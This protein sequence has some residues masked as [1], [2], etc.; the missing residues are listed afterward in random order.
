MAARTNPV[1]LREEQPF[2]RLSDPQ[3]ARKIA[4]AS[5]I[6]DRL[7]PT[8]LSEE[9]LADAER[10]LALHLATLTEKRMEGQGVANS[11]ARYEGRTDMHLDF[12]AYGQQLGLI[13]GDYISLLGPT[14]EPLR[15]AS[16]TVV[17]ANEC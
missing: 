12:T 10:Y 14:D 15:E 4:T 9:V 8:G 6:I 16:F 13:L 1:E 2:A 5:R 17:T 11:N 3:L 7:I